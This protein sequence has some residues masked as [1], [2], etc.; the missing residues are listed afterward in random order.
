M[1]VA[2]LPHTTTE[3]VMFQGLSSTR[4]VLESDS[5]AAFDDPY[6]PIFGA[7]I[8]EEAELMLTM[9]PWLALKGKIC[10]G[11]S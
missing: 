9:R 10:L 11:D 2:I 1:G 8:L 5:R 3:I 7:A 6:G 4:K